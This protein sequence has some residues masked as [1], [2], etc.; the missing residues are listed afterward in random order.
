MRCL[1]RRLRPAQLMLA[2]TMLILTAACSGQPST[3]AGGD[4]G[5]PI[6]LPGGEGGASTTAGSETGS[7]SGSGSGASPGVPAGSPAAGVEASQGSNQLRLD[8]VSLKR[9]D[10]GLVT[11]RVKITNVTGD[12]FYSTS[13][14][15]ESS[16]IDKMN[17]V[18]AVG[19]K[20]YLPVKD[21]EKDCLCSETPG[22]I[23]KGG[24]VDLYAT[25]PPVPTSASSL[26]VSVPTFPPVEHVALG[27]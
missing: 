11:A 2:G 4:P 21:S 19:Q 27:S 26:T 22:S 1:T 16:G 7:G 13:G 9:G 23:P 8:V 24:S 25:F 15:R 20:K 6:Q 3:S 17:L 5:G 12:S 18:D 10:G 14:W